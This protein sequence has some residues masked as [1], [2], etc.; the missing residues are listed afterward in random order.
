MWKYCAGALAVLML[1]PTV[2]AQEEEEQKK[3]AEQAEAAPQSP[4][5]Q[6]SAL[7]TQYRETLNAFMAKYRATTDNQERQKLAQQEYPKLLND[8]A[9][10]FL[11]LYEAHPDDPVADQ[12]LTWIFRYA[13]SSE[14]ASKAAK[15]ALEMVANNLDDASAID[16]LMLIS[17]TRTPQAQEATDMLLENFVNDE[18][19]ARICFSLDDDALRQV[20]EKA[21]NRAVQGHAMVALGRSLLG[22]PVQPNQEGEELLAKVVAEYADIDSFRGKLGAMAE[23]PLFELNHLQIGMVA[24]NIE[25]TDVD[26]EQ[27]DL[28]DY[29]GKVVVL[30]FWGDW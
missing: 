7:S 19:F 17:R 10:K 26:G 16:T 4:A 29:R 2:R 25:G 24:P 28:D 30:D 6:Y 1:L 27:F 20:I 13:A 23:G 22:R 8:Y 5:E 14:A 18:K 3:Q 21:E 12:A 9:D 15:A 11:R